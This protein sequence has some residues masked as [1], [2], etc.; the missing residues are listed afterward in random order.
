MKIIDCFC[1]KSKSAESFKS[2]ILEAYRL[3]KGCGGF[4]VMRTATGAR[5]VLV[6]VWVPPGGMN[7]QYLADESGL[8]QALCFI[9]P[10]QRDVELKV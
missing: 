10:I 4:E 3:L 7:S 5:S 2:T 6:P 1:R 9:R 8:G